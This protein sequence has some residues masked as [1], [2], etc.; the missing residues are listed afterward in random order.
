MIAKLFVS[1]LILFVA[2]FAHADCANYGMAVGVFVDVR[3]SGMSYFEAKQ[4]LLS[5]KKTLGVESFNSYKN[6]LKIAYEIIP[7]TYTAAE[8]SMLSYKS[9][10]DKG[11]SQ[12]N[13]DVCFLS[14]YM[15]GFAANQRDLGKSAENIMH[16]PLAS[17]DETSRNILERAVSLVF[18]RKN[19]KPWPLQVLQFQNCKKNIADLK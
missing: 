13:A 6:F 4:K 8:S 10:K 3:N 17:V 14:A 18:Q 7:N 11:E 5:D 12:V 9:C 1:V 19:M 15:V 2:G 16:G